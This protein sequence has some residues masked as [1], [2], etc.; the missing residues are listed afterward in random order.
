MLTI[1]M[2]AAIIYLHRM[3][4]K[5]RKIALDKGVEDDDLTYFTV[6][7]WLYALPPIVTML[8]VREYSI[9]LLLIFVIIYI[10]GIVYSKMLSRALDKGFD[11]ER[12]AGRDF[13]KAMWLG[14]AGIALALVNWTFVGVNSLLNARQAP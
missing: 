9:L 5:H 8:F 7:L 14:F 6:F 11:Y 13:D 10:P 2:I 3:T 12:K 1:A 4:R